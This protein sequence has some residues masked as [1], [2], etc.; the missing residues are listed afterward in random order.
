MILLAH[1]LNN[2]EQQVEEVYQFTNWLYLE[3]DIV[4]L[5]ERSPGRGTPL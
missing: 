1:I 5:M 3:K 4:L 2:I